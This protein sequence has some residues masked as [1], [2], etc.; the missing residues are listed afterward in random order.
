MNINTLTAIV[1]KAISRAEAEC[2]SCKNFQVSGRNL[3][4]DES[5][6]KFFFQKLA[7][8]YK[9]AI[10]L[11]SSY[12]LTIRLA[13]SYMLTIRLASS[14]KLTIRLASSHKLTIV[15]RKL[16]ESYKLTILRKKLASSYKLTIR[17]RPGF[18]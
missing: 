4:G 18:V 12:K 2:L 13:S 10:R 3:Q 16:A 9:L 6:C 11:A 5:S 7:S 14:Y 17:S 8:S 15:C 1:D